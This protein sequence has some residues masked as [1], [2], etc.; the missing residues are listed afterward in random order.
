MSGF[1]TPGDDRPGK[2]IFSKLSRTAERGNPV[3]LCRFLNCNS[4]P[5]II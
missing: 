3:K 2:V 1:S 4:T 5:Q